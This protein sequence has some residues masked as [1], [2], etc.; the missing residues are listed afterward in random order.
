MKYFW[1]VALT[2]LIAVPSCGR[3]RTLPE[4]CERAFDL[5]DEQ[6]AL[7]V[8]VGPPGVALHYSVD[9]APEPARAPSGEGYVSW[10]E[11]LD[12]PIYPNKEAI[13]E[14]LLPRLDE[15]GG[16][17]FDARGDCRLAVIEGE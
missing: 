5:A 13:E 4:A 17:L 2:L 10:G 11:H 1:P 12:D 15:L 14:Y 16:Q 9:L 6:F 7:M 8:G 3:T